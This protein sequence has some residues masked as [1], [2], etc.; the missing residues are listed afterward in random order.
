M[1]SDPK[2]VGGFQEEKLQPQ[3]LG[4]PAMQGVH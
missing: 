1:N 3:R 2:E 4:P